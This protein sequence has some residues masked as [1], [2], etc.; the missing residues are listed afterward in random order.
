MEELDTAPVLQPIIIEIIRHVQKESTS[1]NWSFDFDI[2]GGNL[3][4]ISVFRDQSEIGWIN[5]F[6]DDGVWPGD[7]RNKD[8]S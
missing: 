3:T 6:A 5:F 7:E 2:F 8:I 4:K 1:T